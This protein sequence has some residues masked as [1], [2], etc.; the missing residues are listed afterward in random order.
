MQDERPQKGPMNGPVGCDEVALP[1]PEMGGLQ[2]LEPGEQQNQVDGPAGCDEV[3]PLERETGPLQ[4]SGSEDWLKG[5]MSSTL[6]RT[7]KR[8]TMR[9]FFFFFGGCLFVFGFGL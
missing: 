2:N 9:R 6:A 5:K 4:T 3:A 1:P 7:Q 8:K